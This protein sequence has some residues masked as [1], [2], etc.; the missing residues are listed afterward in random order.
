MNSKT[1]DHRNSRRSFV[2]C[3][4]L[5]ASAIGGGATDRV[6]EQL[7]KKALRPR[8]ESD[9]IPTLKRGDSIPQKFRAKVPCP[10]YSE[11]S[12]GFEVINL[13]WPVPFWFPAVLRNGY[14]YGDFGVGCP[15]DKGKVYRIT[16]KH[17]PPNVSIPV[18]VELPGPVGGDV[19][20]GPSEHR[21]D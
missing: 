19:F 5:L 6:V 18:G 17:L 14:A 13:S 11:G 20:F 12:I 7:N 16:G 15:Q 21:R 3:L 10:N 4:V 8:D 2:R 1:I 9:V